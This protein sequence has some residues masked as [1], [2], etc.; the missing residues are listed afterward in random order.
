MS[1]PSPAQ[2]NALLQYA[3]Q[4]LGI[5]AEQ[6]AATVSNGGYE[7]LTASLSDSSRRALESLTNDPSQL[8]ALL[9]SEQVK[10]LLKRFSK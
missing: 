5:P 7:A 9:S 6:L 2:M 1:Q 4:K 8:Q 10:Q 3:S